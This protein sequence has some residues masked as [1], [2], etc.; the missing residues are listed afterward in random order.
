M[1]SLKPKADE[2]V[3]KYD[4]IFS[5]HGIKCKLSQKNLEIGVESRTIGLGG[6]DPAIELIQYALK[7]KRE[8]SDTKIKK[9]AWDKNLPRLPRGFLQ[10]LFLQKYIYKKTILG[11]SRDFWFYCYFITSVFIAVIIMLLLILI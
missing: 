7:K 9:I 1:I 3:S 5:A 6:S 11:K 8:K 10:I 4:A 2:L